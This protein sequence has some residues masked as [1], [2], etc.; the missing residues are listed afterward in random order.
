MV[1]A[2]KILHQACQGDFAGM[3]KRRMTQVVSETNSLDQ[4]LVGAQGA[5]NGAADLRHLQRMCQ[6]C[7]EVIAFI[8]D[9]NLRLI[10]QAAEGRGMDDSV[11]VALEGCAVFRFVVQKGAAFRVLASHT[12]W[13][14]RP[15][16]QF[17]EFLTVVK[18][19]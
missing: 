5:S 4:V 2:A 6:A 15:V 7:A 12:V 10:F 13:S 18:Q 8:G 16:F 9:E 3:T 11:A 17:F 19:V 14:Q 1:E